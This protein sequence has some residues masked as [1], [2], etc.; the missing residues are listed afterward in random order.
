[1]DT[2]EFKK[3]VLNLSDD[4]LVNEYFSLMDELSYDYVDA[5]TDKD[6]YYKYWKHDRPAL[7]ERLKIVETELCYRHINL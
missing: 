1:M 5:D 3:Q 4:A 7:Q 6:A 2:K